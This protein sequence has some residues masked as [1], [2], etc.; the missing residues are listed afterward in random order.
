MAELSTPTSGALGPDRPKGG[1]L[2]A[3]QLG[4]EPVPAHHQ[5]LGFLDFFVLWADLGVGL[6]VLL[7]GTYLVP[8]LSFGGAIA[9]IV[10]GTVIGV[11]LLGM[12]GAVGSARG[13]TAMVA[14]RP[15]FGVR[16]S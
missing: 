1:D 13:V 6:L 10:A 16:G 2:A 3:A 15:S 5:V 11:L 7:A 4:I 9:A 8:G 12:A 14:L